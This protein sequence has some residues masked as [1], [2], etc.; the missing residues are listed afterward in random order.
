MIF[1][2]LQPQDIVVVLKLTKYGERRPPYAEIAHEL[3]LSSSRV[4][5]AVSRAK[6]ARLLHGHELG[7]KPNIAALGE[8]LLH[9][10]KY[11]FPAER[12]QLG[13][14]LPTAY[15]AP[16]LNALIAQPDEPPPV[17]PFSDG[18]V[19]GYALYPLHK[20]VPMAALRDS[21]LYEMLALV[22]AIRDGRTRERV[23]AEKEL[24]KR[25]EQRVQ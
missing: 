19:R 5:A 17:W 21:Y 7:E 4:H 20:N 25:L 3:F 22:D 16:P 24:L 15:A 1:M 12:G 23:I 14:G 6:S 9:G 2:N 11:A 13:R 8:F 10:V 18:S